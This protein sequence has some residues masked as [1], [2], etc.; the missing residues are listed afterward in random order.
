MWGKT[1]S[2][3]A[4]R[5]GG[6]GRRGFKSRVDEIWTL[7]NWELQNISN[8]NWYCSVRVCCRPRT[9]TWS[10]KALLPNTSMEP[11]HRH[12]D[13]NLNTDC[14]S[15]LINTFLLLLFFFTMFSFLFSVL[16]C[17]S[18]WIPVLWYIHIYYITVL[19]HLSVRV[20]NP[21]VLHRS[22]CLL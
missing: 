1:A 16:W 19:V 5:I 3:C 12:N 2:E 11:F 10:K 15:Q 22:L 21:F 9:L 14:Y 18:T 4:V 7:H 17:N 8:S 6:R 20:N 13:L